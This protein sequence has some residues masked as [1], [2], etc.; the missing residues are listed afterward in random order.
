MT[1]VKDLLGFEVEYSENHNVYELCDFPNF[2][3]ETPQSKRVFEELEII[4]FNSKKINFP[5]KVDIF[6]R[7]KDMSY[8]DV[9]CFTFRDLFEII[10][11]DENLFVN[12]NTFFKI[13]LEYQNKVC[14]FSI[15]YYTINENGTNT[16]NNT[17]EL[18]RITKT[19]F[20]KKEFIKKFVENKKMKKQNCP[21]FL[22]YFPLIPLLWL[23]YNQNNKL[24]F[25]KYFETI[26]T[27]EYDTELP[28]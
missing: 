1:K 4:N 14:V 7:I 8:K 11:K 27:L 16:I 18:L 6:Q 10:K 19:H 13:H 2:S 21:N 3:D 22:E 25:M 20:R 23:E 15:I 28:F 17:K 5:I 9:M 12:T 24:C 26:E